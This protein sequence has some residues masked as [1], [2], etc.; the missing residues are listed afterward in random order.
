MNLVF[1]GPPGAGKGTQAEL[2][3]VRHGIPHISTGDMFRAAVRADTEVGR[4]AGEYMREGELVPDAIVQQI[5]EARLLQPDC[6]AGF[7]LDGY[8]R[9]L[10]QADALDELLAKWGRELHGV[11]FFEIP[12][13]V[14]VRRITGR[15]ICPKCGTNYHVEYKAP[16]DP[17]CCD[18]DGTELIQRR[19]DAPETV[20]RRLEVFRRW[21]APLVDHYRNRG[22]FLAV[23]AQGTAEE[24]YERISEFV[25]ARTGGLA[26]RVSR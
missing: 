20:T 10:P 16:R 8:P 1:M 5:V 26:R 18:L 15:R 2:F 22:V 9:T 25:A 21:T 24:V 12:E 19:D 6:D 23:N 14:V 17:G 3:H 7:I 13:E 11:I 4:R